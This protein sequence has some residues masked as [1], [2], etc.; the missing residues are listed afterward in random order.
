MA[1]RVILEGLRSGP[2]PASVKVA[3][4]AETVKTADGS[5]ELSAHVS[6]VDGRRYLDY[7]EVKRK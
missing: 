5:Y 3:H 2:A 4:A 6:T 7:T 1:G